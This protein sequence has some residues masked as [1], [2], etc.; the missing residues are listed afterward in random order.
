MLWYVTL[1]N[2]VTTVLNTVCPE[3]VEVIISVLTKTDSVWADVPLESKA[4]TLYKV[5]QTKHD[6]VLPVF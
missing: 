5:H 4:W 3:T 2:T 1:V 6:C